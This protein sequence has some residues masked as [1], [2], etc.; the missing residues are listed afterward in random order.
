[1]KRLFLM[2]LVI[3]LAG[4]LTIPAGAAQKKATFGATA[5]D[6]GNCTVTTTG[7]WSGV[8]VHQVSL[9][10]TTDNT[11]Y[12]PATVNVGKRK[13]SSASSG[14]LSV[15]F[16]VSSLDT[17]GQAHADFYSPKLAIVG[18]ADSS[19]ISITCVP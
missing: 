19:M 16:T 8:R 12:G 4:A 17:T 9:T 6:N 3:G 11:V 7:S 14:T 13:N 18:S 1:V 2:A 15:T 5:T 10:L